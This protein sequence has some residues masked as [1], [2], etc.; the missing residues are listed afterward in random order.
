MALVCA[1]VGP[2]WSRII[3][4]CKAWAGWGVWIAQ[5]SL[6]FSILRARSSPSRRPFA[7]LQLQQFPLQIDPPAVPTQPPIGADDPMAG[8]G[9]GDGIAGDGPCHG[10]GR[11]RAAETPG[12][13][14]V[15]GRLSPGDAAQVLPH[16]A[17]E[18][19]ASDVQVRREVVG[20]P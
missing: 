13:F 9:D 16:L 7:L 2:F 6:V 11:R 4:G 18:G 1:D 20:A 10:P 15:G 17:L 3:I 14:G 12:D 8:D 5:K 19:R